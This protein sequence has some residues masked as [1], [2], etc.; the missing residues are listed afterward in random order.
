MYS[1]ERAFL[2]NAPEVRAYPNQKKSDFFLPPPLSRCISIQRRE[3]GS[4]L[5]PIPPSLAL[6]RSL[7]STICARPSRGGS[8]RILSAKGRFT[9]RSL[10][11]PARPKV[12]IAAAFGNHAANSKYLQLRESAKTAPVDARATRGES[13]VFREVWGMGE[14]DRQVRES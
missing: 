12:F 2:H 14:G 7:T 13:R 9:P 8:R 1:D 6:F 10:F 5:R 4:P 3:G 11:A